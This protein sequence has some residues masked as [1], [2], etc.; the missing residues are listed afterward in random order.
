ML[1][2]FYCRSACV[3]QGSE[4]LTLEAIKSGIQFKKSVAD[5]FLKVSRK[6]K[7]MKC[8]FLGHD[9][10]QFQTVTSKIFITLSVLTL[11]KGLFILD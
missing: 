5:A 3:K 6:Q 4:V 2:F 8:M 10:C 7:Y 11:K 9:P 1:V